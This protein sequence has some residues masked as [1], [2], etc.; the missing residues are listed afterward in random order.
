MYPK[1]KNMIW[2][3][4]EEIII[5]LII[6]VLGKNSLGIYWSK[7]NILN[8]ISGIYADGYDNRPI[9][10]NVTLNSNED[11]SIVLNSMSAVRS[12]VEARKVYNIG[13]ASDAESVGQPSKGDLEAN[14]KKF[15]EAS[16][17]K[18]ADND[19]APANPDTPDS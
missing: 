5:Q 4:G 18:K 16:T 3:I 14:F 12:W 2:N 13:E 19:K 10:E 8:F 17:D 15:L 11:A 1:K 7:Y 9:L 6:Y